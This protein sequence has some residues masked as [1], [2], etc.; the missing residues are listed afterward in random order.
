MR[1]AFIIFTFYLCGS[2]LSGQIVSADGRG[3]VFNEETIIDLRL[4]TNG[5]AISYGKAEI[6][7]YD[8]IKWKSV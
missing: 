2:T 1:I 3:V 5:W 7:Q 6:V 4:H 8:R